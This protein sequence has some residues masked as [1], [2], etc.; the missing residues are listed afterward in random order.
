MIEKLIRD[1]EKIVIAFSGG[2]DSVFLTLNLL[3]LKNKKNLELFLVYVNHKMRNDVDK[4]IKFVK[5]FAKQNNLYFEIV[6]IDKK[7]PS[8]TYS[9]EF[10]YRILRNIK[11]RLGYT[12]IATAHNKDDVVETFLFKLIRGT[13]LD[14]LKS[15]R[16]QN[17]DIIRPILDTYKVDILKYLNQKNQ[18]YVIDSTNI[19][20]TYSRNRI[21]NNILPEMEKINH[22]AKDKIF[23]VIDELKSIDFNHD[24]K[25]KQI[26]SEFDKKNIE[27]NKKLIEN[28]KVFMTKKNGT[29]FLNLN[30]EYNLINEYGKLRI[31]KTQIDFEKINLN[32]NINETIEYSDYLIGFYNSNLFDKK[33]DLEYNILEIKT[34]SNNLKIKSVEPGMSIKTSIGTQKIKKILIDKKISKLERQKIPVVIDNDVIL[35]LGM[36]KKRKND[37]NHN[38]IVFIAK[39]R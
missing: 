29:K 35:L 33:R 14:G 30:N 17:N 23:Q 16:E 19:D 22:L 32:L 37:V 6:E 27:Y 36:I 24:K 21:R 2:P 11:E 7:N 13:S 34:L 1:N 12:K 8:E 38:K 39:R 20:V 28:I 5:E 15:I 9:R 10:R 25:L 31:S 18:N 3:T 26:I 4:D